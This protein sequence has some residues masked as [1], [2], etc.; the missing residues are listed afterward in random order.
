MYVLFTRVRMHHT[1]I[2]LAALHSSF[3][4]HLILLSIG[5]YY[6]EVKLLV[7]N[8]RQKIYEKLSTAQNINRK[9][10]FYYKNY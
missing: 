9:L 8:H 7:K 1:K 6:F 4:F 5:Q 2:L 3:I 10:F